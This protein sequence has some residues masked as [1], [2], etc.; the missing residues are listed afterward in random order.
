MEDLHGLRATCKAMCVACA[1][2][3]VGWSFPL[4]LALERV[5]MDDVNIHERFLFRDTLIDNLA[6]MLKT[7]ADAGH[8]P[9][10]YMLALCLYR[11]NSGAGDDD[12]AMQLIRHVDGKEDARV[13]AM[14]ADGGEGT[15]TM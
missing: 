1:A 14:A 7:A 2:K 15:P 13:L 11:R 9:R 12:E 10:D 3:E 6:K 5:L 8:K 4:G